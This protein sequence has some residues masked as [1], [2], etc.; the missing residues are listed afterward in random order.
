MSNKIYVGLGSNMGD[1]FEIIENSVKFIISNKSNEFVGVSSVYLTRP[2]G[3]RDQPDFLN[4]VLCIQSELKPLALLKKLF[5]I[6]DHF[7]RIRTFKN[8]PRLIDL[9]LLIF[10]NIQ[11]KING[12]IPLTLPHP[13]I[14]KRAFVLKPLIEIQPNCEIP[15]LGKVEDFM[16]ECKN[17]KIT[18]LKKELKI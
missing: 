1:S 7:G 16:K 17:Q 10:G 6:E 12:P 15:G 3:Y 13:E 11:K 2:I 4:A 9:D 8:A 18:R 5:N 14:H